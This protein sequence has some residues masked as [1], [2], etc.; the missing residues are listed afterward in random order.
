MKHRQKPGWHAAALAVTAT[1]LAGV[2]RRVQ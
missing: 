2:R 1:L